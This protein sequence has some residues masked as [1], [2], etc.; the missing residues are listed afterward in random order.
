MEE[1]LSP[2]T[3]SACRDS[4]LVPLYHSW[5][6]VPALP[7]FFS[8]KMLEGSMR[9]AV[10]AFLSDNEPEFIP[11]SLPFAYRS[12]KSININDQSFRACNKESFQQSSVVR[13]TFTV[14]GDERRHIG[15]GILSHILS[16]TYRVSSAG[17]SRDATLLVIRWF[18]SV[19]QDIDG[20]TRGTLRRFNQSE[21][22]PDAVINAFSLT[23]APMLALNTDERQHFIIDFSYRRNSVFHQRPFIYP[24][25]I[26]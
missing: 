14:A 1:T 3:D 6:I 26:S 5:R 24:P 15:Y 9:S 10:L 11:D 4:R 20:H 19:H 23:P 16:T 8:I 2:N 22:Q 17:D 18:D 12:Y 25:A 13:A 21:I 7:A